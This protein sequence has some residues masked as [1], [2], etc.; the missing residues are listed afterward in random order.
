[1]R[2]YS[3]QQGI[4]VNAEEGP[5]IEGHVYTVASGER[6]Q[7]LEFHR[8]PLTEAGLNGLTNEALLAVLIHRTR[9][10][11]MR[12]P[13]KENVMAIAGMTS[14][15]CEFETRSARRTKEREVEAVVYL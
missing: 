9:L 13:C 12:S 11:D 6:Q 4:V 7:R 10:L 14:A 2:I 1:M 15:L 8:G 3:D 5:E